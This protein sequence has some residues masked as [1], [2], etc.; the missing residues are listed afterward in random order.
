MSTVPDDVLL[1][2]VL[3]KELA[4]EKLTAAEARVLKRHE[5]E[6]E[7]RH[8]WRVYAAIPKKDYVAMSGRQYKI[9][10]EQGERYG[11]TALKEPVIDLRALL[12]QV[13]DLLAAKWHQFGKEIEADALL[14]G[15]PGNSPAQE[16]YRS[17]KAD[18][19]GLE[20]EA[21]RGELLP[22]ADVKVGML[23]V[24]NLIRSAVEQIDRE[25]GEE[26]RVILDAALSQAVVEIEE[27]WGVPSGAELTVDS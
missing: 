1:R 3:R 15:G 13:H 11:L 12:R 14:S 22:R 16:R 24:V 5:R 20:V 6:E 21:K 23:V 9:V 27:R 17:Y 8:R 10:D 7:E 19:A 18:L 26:A 2:A 25:F 4:G